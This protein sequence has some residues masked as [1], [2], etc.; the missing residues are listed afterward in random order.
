MVI[1][2]QPEGYVKEHNKLMPL[3]R[4]ALRKY[5]KMIEAMDKRHLIYNRELA[6]VYEAEMA[7]R[8]LVI[9]PDEKLPIGH[10]SHDPEEMRQVY[11]IGREMGNRYID[12]IKDFYT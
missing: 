4:I 1:L 11:E 10:I 7:G 5:P 3:M 6:Y 9:R 2:T 8:V 12:R